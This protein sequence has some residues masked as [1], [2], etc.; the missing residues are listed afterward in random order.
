MAIILSWPDGLIWCEIFWRKYLI[1]KI[2]LTEHKLS[3]E[4]VIVSF[5]GFAI[6]TNIVICYDT[7]MTDVT[8]CIFNHL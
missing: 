1:A 3:R 2:A 4:F 8:D 5:P 7:A 6:M